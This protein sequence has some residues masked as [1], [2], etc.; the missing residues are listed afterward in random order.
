MSMVSG[1]EKFGN[2][3]VGDIIDTFWQTRSH[4]RSLSQDNSS[5]NESASTTPES[6]KVIL[7]ESHALFCDIFI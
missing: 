5:A 7:I 1:E 6:Q 2:L 3:K 4:R